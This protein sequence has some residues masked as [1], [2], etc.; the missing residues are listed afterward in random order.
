MSD[1]TPKP[2]QAVPPRHGH[3]RGR[4]VVVLLA[5]VV[6]AGRQRGVRLPGLPTVTDWRYPPD[7]VELGD[8]HGGWPHKL[9]RGRQLH[10]AHHQHRYTGRD[11]QEL[12]RRRRLEWGLADPGRSKQCVHHGRFVRDVSLMARA[13]RAT[14]RCRRCG[15]GEAVAKRVHRRWENL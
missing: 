14:R 6:M 1:V 13:A 5:L 15:L 8:A 12:H 9:G 3:H 11:G 2:N 4:W 7:L 10:H